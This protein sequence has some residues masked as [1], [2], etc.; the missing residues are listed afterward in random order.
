MRRVALVLSVLAFGCSSSSKAPRKLVIIHT[1]DE[2]SHLLGFAPEADDFP[3]PTTAGTGTIVG[4]AARRK[5][6]FDQQRAAATAAGAES[7]T[8]SAGDNMMGTLAQIAATTAS[9]DYRIMGPKYLAYDVTTLGNHEFDYGPDG[10]AAAIA[11]A[12]ASDGLPP[13]V[14]SNIRFSGGSG[15]AKLAAL[16]DELGSDTS[17]PIHR[18]FTITTKGGLK[19][20]F[21]GI[22]GAD[23]ATLAPLKAPVRF[24]LPAGMTDDSN[25]IA[26]L[27][28]I[29]D[30]IQA[31]VDLLHQVDQVDLVVALSHGSAFPTVPVTGEDADIAANVSGIDVIVSGH[32]HTEVPAQIVTNQ[33]TGKPVLVQQ[34]GRFGD[35][36]GV[37]SLT[38]NGD[39]TVTF[40]MTGS[41]LI[42]V[43]DTIVPDAGVS[44]FI[45]GIVQA[46]ET[47][48]IVAGGPSFM[49]YTLSELLNDAH[50]LNPAVSAT[51]PALTNTG[52]YYNFKLANL[53]YDIDNAN[54][55]QETS[56][57]DLTADA[58]LVAANAALGCSAGTPQNCTQLAIEVS[59]DMRVSAIEKGKTGK[60]GFAD[61]F[62][63]VPL[64]AS[65]VTS[66]PGYPLCRFVIFMAE[67]KAAFEVGA[68]LSYSNDV[69]YIVPSGFKF[70]YDTAR[71]I[72]NPAGDALDP[73]NGRVTKIWM[74]DDLGT[75]LATANFDGPYDQI[76]DASHPGGWLSPVG[77]F[78]PVVAATNLY[79]ATFATFAGVHLKTLTGAPVTN[80]DPT[81]TII[82][83]A[84]TTEVKEWESVG[85]YIDAISTANGG[86]LPPLYDKAVNTV[87]RR[88]TCVGA[89]AT[90]G[91]CSKG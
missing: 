58:Q 2:H 70:E 19:V 86:N 72:F 55:H 60:L 90:N 26:A 17:K 53:G 80:N 81:L 77:P 28:Q 65:P 42:K 6:V 83:R 91:F 1:N 3:P 22:M 69:L 34:A 35:N 27:A 75:A 85:A 56:L 59:G 7:L 52:D 76:Y 50:A 30:D 74:L 29:Y 49:A 31:Q 89:N 62:M 32:S 64:G 24:S 71:P 88:A 38:V 57:L 39:N 25:R 14:S 63:A 9:A 43:N 33:R 18:R 10:L 23:A 82:H 67:V 5:V 54:L 66:T 84:D 13:I 36:V 21:V 44:T 48:P 11:A 37:I 41:H 78:T 79:I 61:M 8:V 40:D 16:F 51:P 46:L 73:A 45:S 15:D 68:G 20:G 12:K 47:A 4:G 87:P